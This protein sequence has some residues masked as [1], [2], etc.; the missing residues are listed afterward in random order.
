MKRFVAFFIMV[1][2]FASTSGFAQNLLNNPDYRKGLEYQSLAQQAYD[3]GDY[4]LSIEYSAS[5]QEYF[6]RA[7]DY[8][9]KMALR[10]TA[11]NLKNR[12]SERLKY[13]D[14]IEAAEHYP[15]EYTGARD[16]F[17]TAE[18]AFAQEEYQL[19]ITGYQ[20][21]IELLKNIAPYI[22]EPRDEL[23]RADALRNFIA[24]NDFASARP[25]EMQRGNTAYDTGKGLI[26][27]ENGRARQFLN[28]AIQNYQLV[29]DSAI[30]ALAAQRRAEVE[31]AKKRADEVD[32][33]TLAAAE[34]AN[35]QSKQNSAETE[36]RAKAYNK[37]WEDSEAAIKG[38]N[39]SYTA[40]LASGKLLPEYYTVRLIP[41]R[42]DCF[43]RIAEYSFVYGDPWKWRLLY[44]ENKHILKDPNNPNLIHPGMRFRIPSLPGEKRSGDW[45]PP[46]GGK[47]SSR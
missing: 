46:A 8:A 33:R 19:S 32:A 18:T 42:R 20:E 27:S 7:K 45:Q 25:T 29:V 10:Y 12:A 24:A 26:G 6:Q 11:Y 2:F 4:D 9:D 1:T 15:Q 22:P 28:T 38:Y 34:Y 40:A 30:N 5:A 37:A 44:N 17:K 41:E 43:W 31:A 35:A 14:S 16:S 21:T 23:A 39:D 13:A 3:E 36:L 47:A